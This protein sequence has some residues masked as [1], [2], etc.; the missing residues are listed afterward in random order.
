MIDRKKKK[1]PLNKFSVS[2]VQNGA[3]YI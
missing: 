2:D 1:K 3:S